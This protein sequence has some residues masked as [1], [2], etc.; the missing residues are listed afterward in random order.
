MYLSRQLRD[1]ALELGEA[2]DLAYAQSHPGLPGTTFDA[3][4]EIGRVEDDRLM[5]PPRSEATGGLETVH[6]GH[7]VV[8]YDDVGIMLIG[9]EDGLRPGARFPDHGETIDLQHLYEH[10]AHVLGVV[11]DDDFRTHGD[12]RHS[13]GANASGARQTLGDPA[14]SL[15]AFLHVHAISGKHLDE[16]SRPLD[17]TA[18]R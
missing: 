7:L 6:A 16:F 15:Q 10:G 8:H 13:G 9:D 18:Y 5:R 11:D 3:G 4:I 17:V 2:L 1:V 14:A 12:L